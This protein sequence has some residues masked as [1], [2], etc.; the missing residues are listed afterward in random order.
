MIEHFPAS[1]STNNSPG[2]TPGF[3]FSKDGNLTVGTYMRIGEVI[4]SSSGHPIIGKNKLVRIRVTCAANAGS[5]TVLQLQSRTAVAT[6]VDI[7]G[8]SITIPAGSYRASADF[9][10]ALG[11]DVELCAYNKSGSTLSNAVMN[12]FLFPDY[13]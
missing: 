5:N 3:V 8:A 2:V 9:D 7:A 11:T 6:R 12:V 13:T 10:I 4:T 1:N